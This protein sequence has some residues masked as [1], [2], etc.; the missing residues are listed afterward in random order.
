[1]SRSYLVVLGAVVL[2]ACGG[3]SDAGDAA[4]ADDEVSAVPERAEVKV[5][6]AESDFDP[7]S[8]G[9]GPEHRT[10]T[11]FDTKARALTS[12]GVILRVRRTDGEKAESTVKLRP[13]SPADV[14]K[15]LRRADGFK[16]ELDVSAGGDG[17]S[18]CSLTR[19]M[20]D[21]DDWADV[22]GEHDAEK[23][24]SHATVAVDPAALVPYGPIASTVWK[25]DARD[26]DEEVTFERW[27]VPGGARTLEA[28]IKVKTK[29]VAEKGDVLLAWLASRGLTRATTQKTK[30]AAALDALS[31]T[32]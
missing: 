6:V 5:L 19:T 7:S 21:R 15:K 26:I 4:S 27:D 23:L 29:N 1:M 32:P 25:V 28:S 16:C 11:F 18:S 9:A 8:L 2:A 13:L 24:L 17:V 31:G 10:V 12:R 20:K 14:E 3:A 30:T 22:V